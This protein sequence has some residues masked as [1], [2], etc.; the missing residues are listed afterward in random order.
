MKTERTYPNE[1]RLV[2]HAREFVAESIGD[3][4]RVFLF[5]VQLMTSELVNNA[6]L[7]AASACTV[8]VEVRDD[9]ITVSVTDTGEGDPTVRAPDDSTFSGR[10]LMIVAALSRDWGIEPATPA[11]GKTVW[12]TVQRPAPTQPRI[13]RGAGRLGDLKRG[14]AVSWLAPWRQGCLPTTPG[15]PVMSGT[16]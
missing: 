9:L 12:F 1:A 13:A 10:G 3:L 4:P 7:H 2:A 8:S 5:D 14:S 15:L 16:G 6:I 11:P